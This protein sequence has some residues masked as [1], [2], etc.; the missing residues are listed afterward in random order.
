MFLSKKILIT[1]AILS[2][3]AGTSVFADEIAQVTGLQDVQATE[4]SVQ[5][6]ETIQGQATATNENVQATVD[7]KVQATPIANTSAG[8]EVDGEA[9]TVASSA[10]VKATGL[11]NA[12]QHVKNENARQHI[13]ANIDKQ[14]AKAESKQEKKS[15]KESK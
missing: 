8:V 7:G 13:Q 11:N 4:N 3:I 14:N 2:V 9:G 1:G 6:K 12:L 5:V 15:E 10:T